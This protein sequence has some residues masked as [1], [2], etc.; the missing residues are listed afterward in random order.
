MKLRILA[1]ALMLAALPAGRNLLAQ[2]ANIKVT[3]VMHADGTRTETVTNVQEGTSEEKTLNAAGKLLRRTVYKLDETGKPVEG[4][5]YSEKGA[6]IYRFTYTRDSFG[7]I[8]EESDFKMDGTLFQRFVYRFT[9]EG[10]VAGVDTFDGQGNLVRGAGGKSTPPKK[11][12]AR[13]R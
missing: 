3:S 11:V 12:P 9:P 4:T 13:R 6:P 2:E 10:R 7:R 8:A 5:A 1:F